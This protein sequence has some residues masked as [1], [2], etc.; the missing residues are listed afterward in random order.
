MIK[1]P[2]RRVE[3]ACR[4]AAPGTEPQ[5]HA[6]AGKANALLRRLICLGAI[7]VSA[8]SQAQELASLRLADLSLEQLS[9]IRVTSVSRTDETLSSSAAAVA[10][11]SSDDIHRSG[12]T[13]VPEVLRT[14]PGVH[15]AR[16]TAS[17]WA[18]STRGFS[19]ANSR[20]LLVLSDTRSIYTPLFSGVFWDAQDYLLEDI[21]RIE[22]VRGPGAAL[23]GSNA[24]NGVIS[25][26]TKNARDTQGGYGEV[27]LGTEEQGV[28]ARYGGKTDGDIYYRAFVKHTEHDNSFAPQAQSQDD[29]R[30]S[31]FGFRTDW[32][33]S[34][35]DS[36][37]LQGDLYQ[38][39]IGQL[40]PAVRVIG[41]P[42]PQGDLEAEIDGGNLLGRWNHQ[43][44]AKSDFQLRAYYDRT[45]RDDPSFIDTLTTTDVEFQHRLE[46]GERH[47]ILWGAGY[48]LSENEN[49]SKGIFRVEP[50]ASE[51]E[52]ISLFIQDQMHVWDKVSLTLGSKFE[53]N[54]FS[55]FEVQPSARVLWDMADR[56]KVWAAV[57][58]AVRVPTRYERDVSIDAGAGPEGSLIRLVGNPDFEP[59]ETIA[60]ELGYRWLAL[61]ELSLDIAL[62]HNRYDDLSSVELGE[63]YV[64]DGQTILPVT[65]MNLNDGR[66]KGLEALITYKPRDNWRL[67]TSYTYVDMDIDKQGL[68]L[69]FE[70]LIEGST[71]RHQLSIT[72]ALD[73]RGYQFDVQLRY[74]SEI[75]SIPEI[76][77]GETIPDYT[78]LTLRLARY[79]GDNI[80]ISLVGQNL[81]DNQHPEFGDRP[82][83]GEIERSLYT[84][85]AFRF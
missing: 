56:Q 72:S 61:D 49:I 71:P 8:A 65:A 26:T 46:L 36:F 2:G 40:V 37:T 10:V 33:S 23:W 64:E 38:G 45:H 48:R 22:V 75:R 62:F 27:L 18:V 34:K 79:I 6:A 69:N 51:D 74:H 70:E 66:S 77:T 35:N 57:S 31:H 11:V 32:D 85:V 78:E 84:K 80:E 21:E 47:E 13:S 7:G 82:L 12:A 15:V 67:R 29:W 50:E 53:H 63:A 19:S 24:V 3:A 68:D 54:D 20:N 55:G 1:I 39:S 28:A 14:V 41:T 76:R 60:Y 52:R 17:V 43:I 44:T 73:W 4:L 58:R 59:E 30:L 25:I 16:Q 81:L 9:T 83:R 5:S 42:G